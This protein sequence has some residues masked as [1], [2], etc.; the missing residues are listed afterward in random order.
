MQ[1]PRPKLRWRV[2]LA[3]I[4]VCTIMC[5][6]ALF[7][8]QL[9]TLTLEQAF[10]TP[11]QMFPPGVDLAQNVESLFSVNNFG[12]LIVNTVLVALVVV[13]G[14]TVLALL[15]GLAFVYFQFPGKWFLFFF[16]LLTLLMPT[17]IIL[18]PLFRIV[19]ELGWLNEATPHPKL[20]LTIPFL[21]TATGAFL[22][23]QH[24]S[25]LPRE[26]AEAAQIDG[27]TPLRFMMSVLI[28][29]SWNVIGAHAL[30]QFISAWNQY[31]W[32]VLIIQERAEQVIQVGVRNAVN[33][34]TST[35]YG[36]LMAAGIV[37]SL[38]PLILFVVMQKQFMS[39]FAL[40]RDK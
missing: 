15:A 2:H 38:P 14:K 34:G 31:L 24:F 4:I 39:G 11:P 18:L 16:V 23:R 32:P 29:M 17:E 33:V 6:P 12:G 10:L 7:A 26:L 25:N 30:I 28:P 35:D 3:L 21:A 22:F 19:S 8:L 5:F 1:S 36:L 27:A 37:A 20:A 40:T 9:A 13:I